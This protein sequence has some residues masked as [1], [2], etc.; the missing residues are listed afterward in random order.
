VKKEIANL[1][2]P[3]RDKLMDIGRRFLAERAVSVLKSGN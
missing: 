2:H 1:E 3:T